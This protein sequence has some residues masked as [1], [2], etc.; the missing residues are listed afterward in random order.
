MVDQYQGT[1]DF[2]SETFKLKL[3]SSILSTNFNSVK[4]K[5]RVKL[6]F[7]TT[8][9]SIMANQS[10]TESM[11]LPLPPNMEPRQC[12]FDQSHLKVFTLF[13]LD[14]WSMIQNIPKFHVPPLLSK[15]Q[16][17]SEECKTEDKTLLFILSSKPNLSTID[18]QIMLSLKLRDL[19]SQTKLF[20]PVATLIPGTLDHKLEPTMMEED[21]SLSSK[22]S[23]CSKDS[24]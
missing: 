5:F 13:T 12:L 4:V 22:L 1:F 9:G 18:T 14:I 16:K 20:L 3:S 2:I 8:N 7:S 19:K 11:A 15:T 17:C 6:F 10:I 24:D 21:S 23:E